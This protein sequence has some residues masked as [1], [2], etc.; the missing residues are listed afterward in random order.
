ML[1]DCQIIEMSVEIKNYAIKLRQ[2]YKIKIPDA[3]IASSSIIHGLPLISSDADFKK[4]KELN[5][6]FLEK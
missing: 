1:N 3:I 5:L 6:I 4:I 2:N